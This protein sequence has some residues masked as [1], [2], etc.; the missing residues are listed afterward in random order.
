MKTLD[1]FERGKLSIIAAEYVS[2][3]ESLLWELCTDLENEI[4]ARYPGRIEQ[5]IQKRR[6]ERDMDPCRRARAVLGK[7]L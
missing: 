3:I 6:Y 7:P 2:E 1:A 5:P 4:D